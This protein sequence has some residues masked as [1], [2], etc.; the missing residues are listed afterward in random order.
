MTT[1]ERASGPESEPAAT[2]ARAYHERTRHSPDSVRRS[3]YRLNWENQPIPF[4]IY[5]SDLPVVALPQQV[6]PSDARMI[7]TLLRGVPADENTPLDLPHLARILFLSAGVV[8]TRRYPSGHLQMFRAAACTGAL[9]HIDVYVACADIDGLE[10]GVYHF[11][12]HDFALRRLRAGDHRGA[13]V[14]AT[15]GAREIAEAQAVLVLASTYWRNSWKY[16]ERAYRHSYW[17]SGT[18][19]A[20]VLALADADGIASKVFAGF[21]DAEVERLLGLD[22]QCEGVTALVALGRGQRRPEP[23]DSAA[24][25]APLELATQPLSPRPVHYALLTHTHH[26]TAMTSP[27]Q[28]AA[29]RAGAMLRR[30]PEAGDGARELAPPAIADRSLDETI[31]RRGSAR[32]FEQAPITEEELSALLACAASGMDCDFARSRADRVCDTYVIVHDAGDLPMGAYYYD[33]GSG[34]LQPL[35]ARVTRH[36][37]GFVALEQDLAADAAVNVYSLCDLEGVFRALGGRG[38]R[39]ASLEGAVAGGR[40]YLAA[41]AMGLGAT[42]LTFYDDYATQTFE[43]HAE[44]KSV[45]FLTAV[46]HRTRSSA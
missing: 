23:G 36:G 37:S 32:L 39:A 16:R 44:G 38:Y 30:G 1:P 46:G 29:W 15:G 5:T 9:Y 45:M 8:R 4:K 34:R 17:D 28:V 3:G 43:P 24:A 20:N 42:G 33:A 12:P 13:L 26:A 11:G 14:E 35:S 2:A 31:L 6:P 10:A 41:Y 22:P 7:E 21:V 27:G 25:L 19:L 40:A 18:I